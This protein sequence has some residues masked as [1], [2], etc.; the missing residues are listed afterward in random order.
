MRAKLAALALVMA[1]LSLFPCVRPASAD[2]IVTVNFTAV[3][4][5]FVLPGDT[6][7]VTVTGQYQFD[8]T[9][10]SVGAWSYDVPSF[11]QAGMTINLGLV[12]GTSGSFF[13]GASLGDDLVIFGDEH[14]FQG[15]GS[16]IDLL[17]EPPTDI[18]PV[19][20]SLH[21][22]PCDPTS[23][24]S[25]ADFTSIDLTQ[26]SVGAPEPSSLLLLGCG[27]FGLLAMAS[28]GSRFRRF[29]S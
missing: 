4:D 10:D 2:D 22:C 17:V 23:G 15:T 29:A 16:S 14:F 9:N 5:P 18:V 8:E 24:D 7:S 28:F 12:S 11:I 20:G 27:L 26:A 6:T 1:S 19:S 25:I 3:A 21:F 13:L